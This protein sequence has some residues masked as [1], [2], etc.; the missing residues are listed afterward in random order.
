MFY[1]SRAVHQFDSRIAIKFEHLT[2]DNMCKMIE[3]NVFGRIHVYFL[4]TTFFAEGRQ[5]SPLLK[6]EFYVVS[7]YTPCISTGYESHCNVFLEQK[8]DFFSKYRYF[9]ICQYLNS[10]DS[11]LGEKWYID[12]IKHR[13]GKSCNNY[14]KL[15]ASYSEWIRLSFLIQSNFSVWQVMFSRETRFKGWYDWNPD[16]VSGSNLR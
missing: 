11:G 8:T 3:N 4:P 15:D 16:I 12:L 9:E 1:F 6:I 13:H 5:R 14:V 2:D 7:V 10:Q